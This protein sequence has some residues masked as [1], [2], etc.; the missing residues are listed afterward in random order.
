MDSA[1]CKIAALLADLLKPRLSS[2][3]RDN[4]R[5]VTVLI[6]FVALHAE[7]YLLVMNK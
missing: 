5:F 1:E 2:L 6:V 7:Q 3:F 4:L